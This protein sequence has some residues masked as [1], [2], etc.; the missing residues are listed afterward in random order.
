MAVDGYT[1]GVARQAQQEAAEWKAYARG[2][3]RKLA[4]Y[5]DNYDGM[6]ALKNAAMKEL[7][8]IDPGRLAAFVCL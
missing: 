5:A 3:E 8:R 4:T 1:L 2:L 6:E 7:S